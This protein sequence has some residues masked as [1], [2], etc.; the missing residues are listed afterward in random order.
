MIRNLTFLILVLAGSAS[1]LSA[2]EPNMLWIITDDQ[3]ADSIAAFNRMIRKQDD[4]PLGK[5]L[6]PNVDRLAEAGTTFLY[7]FNQNPG[8]APSRTSMHTGRYSHRTGVYGFEYYDPRG[9]EHW[10]PMFPEILR[11]EAGYQTVMAGKRGIRAKHFANN[12]WQLKQ[13][14]KTLYDVNLGYR[15]EFFKAGLTEWHSESIWSKGKMGP[16]TEYYFPSDGEKLA[17]PEEKDAKPNDE[18][19]IR[20]RFDLLCHYKPGGN[21]ATATGEIIGGVNPQTVDGTREYHFVQAM[22]RH[23]NQEGGEYTDL[24]GV[25]RQGLDPKRPVFAYCGFEFPHTPVLP[26]E[27]FRKQFANETYKVPEFTDRELAEFPPQIQKMFGNW[28]TDHFT[29]EEKQQMIRDYYAYCAYGDSLVGQMADGFIK[30]SEKQGRP[31][32]ILYVCG[33]HGW[34]LNEHGMASKFLHYD[35][36]LH[37]PVVVVSS[38]KKK[39]PA[40]KV[41][42]ELTEFVDMAPTFLAAGGVDVDDKRYDYLDGRDFAKTAAGSIRPRDYVIAQP[43]W[44]IGP[45]AVIR[46]KDYK[47]AMRIRPRK[48]LGVLPANAGKDMKWAINADLKDVE[49]TLFDL[50]EDPDETKNLAF[51]PRYEPVLKALRTKLQNIVLGDQAVEVHWTGKGGSPVKISNFAKGADDNKLEVPEPNPS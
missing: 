51:D 31:W 4:S 37:N 11:D 6:S 5:V 8:C 24:T 10:R 41:V 34:R 47:Y 19:E 38:D 44:V 30:F 26:P 15:N 49:P 20:K 43:T 28:N 42:R 23:L 13:G 7:T 32:M 3:R 22:L 36:D 1:Q 33:D 46:T 45:R 14:M 21:A 27:E 39:F 12:E 9:M 50:K 35:I 16:K 48:S 2:E 40:G 18:A 29:A 17:W 25:K